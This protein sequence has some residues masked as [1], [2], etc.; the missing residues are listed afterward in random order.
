MIAT[1]NAKSCEEIKSFLSRMSDVYKVP[2]ETHPKDRLRQCVFGGT[3]NTEQFLPFDRSGNRRFLPV[4]TDR[5]QMEK[6]ILDD[7]NYSRRYID[8]LW[9]EAMTLYRNRDFS[10]KF[11][12]EME[13][14]L[15]QKLNDHMPE[16]TKVGVIQ[17]FLDHCTERYVCSR[18]I[19]E[20]AFH[21]EGQ[22]PK[23]WELREI[24]DIMNGSI[25]GWR[26]VKQHRY[27]EYGVQLSWERITEGAASDTAI[28][29]GTGVSDGFVTV[30]KQMQIPFN[31]IE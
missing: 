10:L 9:A 25:K 18:M 28:S 11:S 26:R 19:Y 13:Q 30:T 12:P 6:H 5:N 31:E 27:P 23:M 20:K 3:T 1:M 22:E 17:A 8:Q 2:Y 24:N 14:I 29:R 7:E 21:R 15:E 4:K 16:D